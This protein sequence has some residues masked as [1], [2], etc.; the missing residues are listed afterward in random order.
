M[1]I[2]LWCNLGMCYRL[3]LLST[4]SAQPLF[5]SNNLGSYQ[6]LVSRK[7]TRSVSRYTW[8]WR[9][10]LPSLDLFLKKSKKKRWVVRNKYKTQVIFNSNNK[11]ICCTKNLISKV[12]LSFISLSQQLKIFVLL[13]NKTQVIHIQFK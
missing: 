3:S 5:R 7:D 11:Y 6:L 8:T 2:F 12:T 13:K 1:S 10:T 9:E 4:Q